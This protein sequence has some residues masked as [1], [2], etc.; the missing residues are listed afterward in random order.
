M[1]TSRTTA[2]SLSVPAE[3]RLWRGRALP[4]LRGT[5][6]DV[7][8][9]SGLSG[10]AL[11]PGAQ[12]LALEPR[13]GRRLAAAVRSRPRSRV[14]AAPAERIPLE[15]ASVDAVICS[16]ALCSVTDP[17][18]ALA[19]I[20]RVLRPH[21]RFVFFEHVAAAPGTS[22]RRVQKLISPL[23]RCLGHGCDPCR[24]TAAHIRR[25]GFSNLELE[26]VRTGGL[27]GGLAPVIRGWALR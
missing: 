5:V 21:G 12:W 20:L 10:A 8:A 6:L 14:L 17:V 27:A 23:S 4:G 2:T 24:D 3:Q 26:T 1:S 16:T 11:D 25:A 19:E 15:D 22:A 9:G 7:G 18:G 13:P